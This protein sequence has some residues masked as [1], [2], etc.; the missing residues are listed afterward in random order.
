MSW[1]N[2]VSLEGGGRLFGAVF[3]A[4]FDRFGF[5]F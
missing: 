5:A 1:A 2:P 3:L 4:G